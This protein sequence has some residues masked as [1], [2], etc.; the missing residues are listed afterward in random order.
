MATIHPIGMIP[1]AMAIGPP[2]AIRTPIRPAVPDIKQHLLR[3]G[4][5]LPAPAVLGQE[6][7]ERP[8]EQLGLDLARGPGGAPHVGARPRKGPEHGRARSRHD[9][10]PQALVRAPPVVDVDLLRPV[11][12]DLARLGELGRVAAGGDEVDEQ[13][14]A[15]GEGGGLAAV[16][17]GCVGGCCDAEDTCGCRVKSESE[18]WSGVLV[19]VCLP[20]PGF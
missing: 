19:Q 8:A 13:A 11:E 5:R 10:A 12:A 4:E 1:I 3:H 18:W 16:V 7:G 9:R 14:C 2:M 17:Q 6:H 20:F 15:C